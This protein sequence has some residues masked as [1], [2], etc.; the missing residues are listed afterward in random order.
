MKLTVKNKTL[1][2]LFLVLGL[3]IGSIAWEVLER[4]IHLMPGLSDFSLTMNEP[5]TLF[6]FYVLAVSFRG[7][8]GTILGSIA[9]IILFFTI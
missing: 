3:L 1:F 7:N 5:L 9:G 4:I 6:D 8:P 2:L